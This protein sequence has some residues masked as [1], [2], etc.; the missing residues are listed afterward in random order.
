MRMERGYIH[1]RRLRF[2]AFHGVLPQER[3]AGNDYEVSVRIG[4]PVCDAIGSDDVSDTLDY[5]A[6]YDV[7]T[8]KMAEPANLVER[9]AGNIVSELAEEFPLITSIDIEVTKLNP[10]MGADC[11]G[12]G[13][14]LHFIK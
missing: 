5:A 8:R 13:V 12:A 14:E 4:Y 7:I 11:D 3:V 6:V 9:V 10:P 2:H 1:M